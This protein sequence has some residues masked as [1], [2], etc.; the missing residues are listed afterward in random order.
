MLSD[1]AIYGLMIRAFLVTINYLVTKRQILV[2]IGKLICQPRKF[3]FAKKSNSASCV[4][5]RGISTKNWSP[6]D[7]SLLVWWW[8]EDGES[9]I[10]DL[11]YCIDQVSNIWPKI[12]VPKRI[13]ETNNLFWLQLYSSLLLSRDNHFPPFASDYFVLIGNASLF[14][15][16]SKDI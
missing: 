15:G 2:F 6:F 10:H 9:L 14:D 13:R 4:C 11:I 12:T 16:N 1:E 8:N 3:S 7:V 5:I